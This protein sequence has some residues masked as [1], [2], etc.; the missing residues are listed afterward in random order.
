MARRGSQLGTISNYF[1]GH[2]LQNLGNG[3]QRLANSA[4]RNLRQ[5]IGPQRG[6]PA[7]VDTLPVRRVG[8][9]HDTGVRRRRQE[10]R[11]NRHARNI[12]GTINPRN[13]QKVMISL[14]PRLNPVPRGTGKHI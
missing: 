14:R 2:N 12:N 9:N 3:H 7:S 1:T 13:V 10:Q 6:H 4:S 5:S 8:H 11:G